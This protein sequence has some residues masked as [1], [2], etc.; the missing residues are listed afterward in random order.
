MSPHNLPMMKKIFITLLSVFCL[1]IC[2]FAQHEGSKIDFKSIDLPT[3][4]KMAKESNKMVFCNFSTTWCSPCKALFADVY[5]DDEVGVY[6]NDKFISLYI[7]AEAKEWVDVAKK[8]KITG[9]PTMII[10][11]A[12]GGEKYRM[13]GGKTK[14][15]FMTEMKQATDDKRS[16][17]ALKKRYEGGERSPE[18][19]YDYAYLQMRSGDE[20]KGY[21][22][23]ENYFNSLSDSGKA[24]KENWFLFTTFSTGIEDSRGK[25][26]IN[27]YKNF[28]ASND[29]KVIDNQVTKFA[30][31]AIM[32]YISGYFIRENKF[33]QDKLNADIALITKLELDSRPMLDALINIAKARVK[34]ELDEK[35]KCENFVKVCQ[36][37]I[38][39]LGKSEH[40]LLVCNFSFMTLKASDKAKTIALEIMADYKAKYEEK[41]PLNDVLGRL[42]KDL[43]PIKRGDI[44]SFESE[45][46]TFNMALSKAKKANKLIFID[47][48]T[49]W[50]GPCKKLSEEVFT[51][52]SVKKYFDK[53]FINMKI[54]ME[55]GEG[56]ELAKRFKIKG[57]PTLL[58]I[59][60]EGE[61]VL[62]EVG[63]MDAEKFLEKFKTANENYNK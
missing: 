30:R 58:L 12:D 35:D 13:V 47:C 56:I 27:N 50:C 6:M 24:A 31:F 42:M 39:N 26:L 8:H 32:P 1:T 46:V 22:I 29:K 62:S 28:Y 17:E 57:Y 16:P 15:G 33:N 10:L 40:F 48:Y 11:D 9:Y 52:S 43:K 38:K 2:S 44:I 36:S 14:T 41:A 21:E 53:N 63:S 37:E 49:V 7:N 45:S 4:L 59:N 3:A 5:C 20:V 60:G 23:I 55:K 34:S 19:V 54:D 18:L 61:I 25:Y 51:V